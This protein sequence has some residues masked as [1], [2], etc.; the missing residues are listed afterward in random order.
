MSALSGSNHSPFQDSLTHSEVKNPYI[1]ARAS[2]R[3][4]MIHFFLSMKEI[5]A[6][7][8]ESAKREN[9]NVKLKAPD[10][11]IKGG[12]GLRLKK[13]SEMQVG[14]SNNLL[15][16]DFFTAPILSMPHQKSG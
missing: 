6:V 15:D 16:W 11:L 13:Q 8:M 14:S 10:L 5:Y 1:P 7:D 4:R 3:E 12:R 9:L 2:K